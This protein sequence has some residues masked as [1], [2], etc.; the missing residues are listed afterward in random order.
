MVGFRNMFTE[1]DELVALVTRT[2]LYRSLPR[3]MIQEHRF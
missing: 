1:L 2:L 3:K